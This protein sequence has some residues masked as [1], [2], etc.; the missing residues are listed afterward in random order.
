MGPVHLGLVRLHA[1]KFKV[2]D[3]AHPIADQ[4]VGTTQG[5]SDGGFAALRQSILA[6]SGKGPGQRRMRHIQ[7]GRQGAGLSDML[8]QRLNR[9]GQAAGGAARQL[10]H[11]EGARRNLRGFDLVAAADRRG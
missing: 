10:Q 2:G 6:D 7:P 5:F 4:P 8:S 9:I 3:D 1:L 11:L